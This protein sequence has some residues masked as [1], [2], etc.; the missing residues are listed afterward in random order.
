MGKLQKIKMM[1]QSLLLQ[2][3]AITT[4]KAVIQ[5]DGDKIAEGMMV[6]SIDKDGNK[7]E[8]EDGTYKTEE[9]TEIRVE[10]HKVVY[11][12][13]TVQELMEA[14]EP[15][16]Q[17]EETVETTEVTEEPVKQTEETTEEPVVVV[18][19]V[20]QQET[21]KVDY[22]KLIGDLTTKITD[23]ET[24]LATLE[25]R[26]QAEPITETYKSMNRIEKTGNKQLDKLAELMRS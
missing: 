23:L 24:K 1:L 12:S 4:D 17:P 20:E 18:E 11:L 22:L 7:I 9:G 21:E 25:A 2:F 3:N 19:T 6:W 10:A 16:E 26:P 15:V 14:Q 8:I 13:D 5:F